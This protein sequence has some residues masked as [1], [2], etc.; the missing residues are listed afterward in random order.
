MPKRNRERIALDNDVLT[1]AR[2]R[3][4]HAYDQFDHIAVAFSGGKDSTVCL[5]LALAEAERRGRLPLDVIHWDEEAIPYATEHYVRRRYRD[6]RLALRWYCLPVRHFNACARSEPWWYCWD[7]D[8]KHLWVR[9]MPP[10]GITELAGFPI[11]PPEA[12]IGIPETNGLIHPPEQYG[13]VGVIL[14]IRADESLRR[15]QAIVARDVDNYLVPIPRGGTDA[16]NITKV[17]P[18]YDFT[19]EDIWR[20]IATGGRPDLPVEQQRSWDYN[21]AYD[22]MEMAGIAPFLQRCAP[23]YG[24]EPIRG[25][26]VFAQCW[27]DIWDRMA[28]RVAGADTA[29][30]YA[31]TELYNY[32]KKTVTKPDDVSW[33]QFLIHYLNKFPPDVRRQT[34]ERIRDE[35]RRHYKVTDEPILDVARHPVTGLSWNFLVDL[36]SRSDPKSRKMAHTGIAHSDDPRVAAQLREKYDLERRYLISTGRLDPRRRSGTLTA[37]RVTSEQA[38][39]MDAA[40]ADDPEPT[41]PV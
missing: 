5:E 4:A 7:P 22:D 25:L 38:R 28:A 34:A 31:R 26:H 39:S 27:P 41:A 40:F 36:A 11:Q 16:G 24:T 23:P 3:V 13:Q 18:I 33:E 37:P 30:R 19:T 2:R 9:P 20:A 1:E 15:Y 14:G 8:R 29:A 21:T 12:R 32:G 6:P 35:I 17:Y 10:E